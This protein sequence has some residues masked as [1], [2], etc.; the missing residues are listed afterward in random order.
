MDIKP[1]DM[2]DVLEVITC[3]EFHPH[4]PSLCVYGTSRG[5]MTVLDM[6][7]K[8]CFDRNMAMSMDAAG[9]QTFGGSFDEVKAGAHAANTLHGSA[10][11][12]HHHLIPTNA[13]VNSSSPWSP[14][15]SGGS[16][17]GSPPPPSI[18]RQSSVPVD[19]ILSEMVRSI[20]DIKYVL[21]RHFSSGD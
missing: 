20:S 8:A 19:P 21:F 13:E 2:E 5:A 16:F 11:A 12:M 14:H 15:K 6:R 1:D 3:A 10:T 7:M 9:V 17:V 18:M 4:N